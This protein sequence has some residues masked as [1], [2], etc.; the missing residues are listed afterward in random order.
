MIYLPTAPIY[1][2]LFSTTVNHNNNNK[3]NSFTTLDPQRSFVKKKLSF[4]ITISVTRL[5]D[6]SKFFETYFLRKIGKIFG[7]L[8]VYFE[9]HQFLGKT[10]VDTFWATFR[11]NWA[12]FYTAIW[13]H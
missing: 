11:R 3:S 12:T 10:T 2:S 4:N 9:I 5:G 8:L 1:L 13:S 6:F 7:H